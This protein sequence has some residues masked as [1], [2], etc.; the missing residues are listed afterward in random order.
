[1]FSLHDSFYLGKSNVM[2]AISFVLG[3]QS[4]QVIFWHL[5]FVCSHY[6]F[7]LRGQGFKDLIHKKNTEEERPADRE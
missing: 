5:P 2:D 7:Q 3:V 4:A 1:M 6:F